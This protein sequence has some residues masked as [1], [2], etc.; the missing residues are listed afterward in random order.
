MITPENVQH[1]A[2]QMVSIAKE[3]GHFILQQEV[4]TVTEKGGAANVVTDIDVKSQHL[5]MQACEQ[6][7]PGTAAFP[8]LC[9]TRKRA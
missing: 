6:C 3:A 1:L 9:T 8:W 4:H 2:Q 5:L 7:L